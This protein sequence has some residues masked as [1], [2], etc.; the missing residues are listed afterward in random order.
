MAEGQIAAEGQV[1]AKEVDA[2]ADEAGNAIVAV[3]AN[4]ADLVDKATDATDTN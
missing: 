1:E 2:K 3:G 4:K